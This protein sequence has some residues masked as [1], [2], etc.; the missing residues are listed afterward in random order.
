[1]ALCWVHDGRHYKKLSPVFKYNASK[2]TKFLEKYWK[3]YHKL[4]DYKSTP[5][6]ETAKTLSDEFDQLFST[7]TEYNELD[8]RIAKT[9]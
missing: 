7:V 3:Y 5:S 9:K 1:M 8:D 6:V 4:L 2:V